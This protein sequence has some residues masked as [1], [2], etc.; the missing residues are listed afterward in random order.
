M[1][2]RHA[3][4]AALPDATRIASVA[5]QVGDL[6][7]SVWFYTVVIGLRPISA[8]DGQAALGVAGTTL[9]ELHELP[10]ATPVVVLATGMYHL[11]ILVGSRVELGRS[12]ARLVGRRYALGGASDHLVSEALYLS[13]PDGN[14][15]EIYRDRPRADWPMLDGRPKIDTLPLDLRALLDDARTAT[16]PWTG[17]ADDATLGHIHLQVHDLAAVRAF[18]VDLLGFEVIAD[19]SA[20]GALF[21]SAGG[22]HHHIGLN[23]WHSRDGSRR[24]TTAAGLISFEVS[25]GDPEALSALEGRLRAADLQPEGGDG[26]LSVEDPAG[27]TVILSADPSSTGDATGAEAE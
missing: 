6:E 11:A 26:Y 23:T 19:M 21:V 18:Y 10:G 5:L 15:I 20:M 2:D 24:P 1:I 16:R 4:T 27:N 7:R 13:D 12:L 9:V 3:S 8:T 17:L 22:Y 25:V 14:G